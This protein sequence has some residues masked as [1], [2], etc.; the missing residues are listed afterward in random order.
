MKKKKDKTNRRLLI[1]FIILVITVCITLTIILGKG[2]IFGIRL[3]SI[4]EELVEETHTISA[5]ADSYYISADEGETELY[6]TIDGEDDESGY[7][8]TVSDEDVVEVE[9]NIVTAVDEGTATLTISS[10]EY[11]DVQSEVVINVVNTITKLVLKTEYESIKVGG[12]TGMSYTYEPAKATVNIRYASSD[13]E[14]AV[15]DS[16]GVVTGVSKGTVTIIATDEI[17]GK[18][19]S[20][21]IKVK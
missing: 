20:Y 5:V 4:S 15:V 17:S 13:E 9:G 14:I 21:S 18:T 1:T 11:E 12:E 7:T 8:I 16:N 19:A 6:I 10:D 2:K 3:I